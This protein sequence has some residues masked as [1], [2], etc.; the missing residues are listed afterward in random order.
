M[1]TRSAGPLEEIPASSSVKKPIGKAKVVATRK[2]AL[3]KQTA[4][5][6]R[7]N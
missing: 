1:R 5:I 7:Y 2:P 4:Q 3:R 6:K